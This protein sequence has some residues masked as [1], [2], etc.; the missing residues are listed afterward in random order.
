MRSKNPY[1]SSLAWLMGVGLS[2]SACDLM[3]AAPSSV[4]I[5]K[6]NAVTL[7]EHFDVGG[8]RLRMKC[9]GQGT[10]TVI[11][12]AGMGE[13][14]IES[15]TWDK[16]I[17]VVAQS[18]RICIYDRAGLGSSEPPL[19]TPRTVADIAKDLNALLLKSKA[20]TPYVLVGHSIGGMN[21]RMYAELHPTN[22]AGIVLIDASHPDQWSMWRDALPVERPNELD[23]ITKSRQHLTAQIENPSAN[24]ENLDL[25]TS[26]SQVRNAKGFGDIPLIVLTHSPN[27]RMVPDL[28]D[29]LLK[30]LEAI[31]QSLQRDLTSLSSVTTHRIADSAGHYIHAEDPD[32]VVNAILELTQR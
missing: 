26:A 19:K 11:V 6:S 8:Y 13:P 15:Q 21:M 10:P 30:T 32:L 17:E 9:K 23:S 4:D 22:I 2:I 20:Q 12:D 5:P 27:W 3:S 24:P 25:S 18:T 1:L 16:V 28:P 29:E 31:S 14:P 7:D